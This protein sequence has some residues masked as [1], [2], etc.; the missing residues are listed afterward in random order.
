MRIDNQHDY[1]QA[2]DNSYCL[3]TVDGDEDPMAVY[4]NMSEEGAYCVLT[5]FDNK[6]R[7]QQATVVPFST[8]E[9]SASQPR[10]RAVLLQKKDREPMVF[11]YFRRP[12]RNWKRG[13]IFRD[14]GVQRYDGAQMPY[15]NLDGVQQRKMAYELLLGEPV[16]RT[17]D[18]A[19]NML[20]GWDYAAVPLSGELVLSRMGPDCTLFWQAIN[21]GRVDRDTHHI[22]VCKEYEALVPKL[23]DHT[24]VV[25]VY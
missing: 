2:Y 24:E 11:H 5:T 12:V 1:V 3:I 7:R 17:T 10:A 25:H 15:Q 14:H 23:N 6:G 18:E 8:V 21:I 4:T 9:W 22:H 16:M 20:H 13:L 19:V